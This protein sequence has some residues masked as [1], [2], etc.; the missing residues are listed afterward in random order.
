MAISD[1][2]LMVH[3]YRATRDGRIAFGKGGG[4]LA[5]GGRI[6]AVA[7]RALAGRRAVVRMRC[8]PIYAWL[9]RAA[10]D[11]NW[12]GPIDRTLDGMPFFHEVGRAD[13]IAGAGFSGNGVGPSVLGGKI[14]AS[15]ALGREDEWSRA[16]WSGG[17][18]TA[19]RRSRSATSAAPRPQ[20]GRPQGA[21]E[22]AG[23]RRRSSRRGD[24]TARAAR[25]RPD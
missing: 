6:G 8:A 17:R 2:R 1:S 23:D 9:R 15:M 25:A 5:F 20:R 14:L 10:I 22:D 13:L 12:A 19:C 21:S 4:R 7:E 18:R 3:Y 24:V 16:A 11:S